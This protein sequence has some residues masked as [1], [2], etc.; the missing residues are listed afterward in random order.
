MTNA[1]AFMKKLAGE[2]EDEAQKSSSS[3]FASFRT[4]RRS[5]ENADEVAS[6]STAARVDPLRVTDSRSTGGTSLATRPPT[7]PR[8]LSR[9]GSISLSRNF[10]V[11][12][13]DARHSVSGLH[14]DTALK[15]KKEA[16]D[17]E[18]MVDAKRFLTRQAEVLIAVAVCL[19]LYDFLAGYTGAIHVS[20]QEITYLL[21]VRYCGL[22]PALLLTRQLISGTGRSEEA[23]SPARI[24]AFSLSLVVVPTVALLAQISLVG[25]EVRPCTALV[26]AAAPR[27]D[28][29]QEGMPPSAPPSLEQGSA[30][31]PADADPRICAL[32]G[33]AA[34]Y[35]HVGYNADFVRTLGMLSIVCNY[36][37]VYSR[38]ST[39][40]SASVIASIVSLAWVLI[41]QLTMLYA[42]GTARD[43]SATWGFAEMGALALWW[44]LAHLVG[45]LHYWLR[46]INLF[47]AEVL[48]KRHYRLLASIRE[49]TEHCERLLKN[50]L[51]P[52]VLVHLGGLLAHADHAAKGNMLQ[53][54]TI[55]ER[56]HDCSFLFAKIGG[57][58]KLVNDDSVDPKDM[59]TVL[60][61][62]FDRFDALADMFGVQKVRKTANEYYLVAAGLPNPR[63]LPSPE[64]RANGIAGF[65]FAMIN[66]MNIINLE[67][68]E[69][70]ITFTCQVR[71]E[72]VT[73]PRARLARAARI[74]CEPPPRRMRA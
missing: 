14:V 53:A 48:R 52:H 70:G 16:E 13:A 44:A 24:L 71:R 15:A 35:C 11:R 67:L 6:R 65:G 58:S 66:I 4:K 38:L 62:M 31:V 22:V 60:Q 8:Q 34:G 21:I 25:D 1:I 47:Q 23:P 42:A 3:M 37:L 57:L 61:I 17:T 41:S 46:Y 59:M 19:G 50:I 27:C 64:D 68:A 10:F 49:E 40:M 36:M 18:R 20:N 26:A 2:G 5:Q 63:I 54:K 51:P 73:P 33:A 29:N 45:L 12:K 74:A 43:R 28:A 30:A 72:H 39:L 32:G 55:A 69:Y 9:E 7:A 56:Y